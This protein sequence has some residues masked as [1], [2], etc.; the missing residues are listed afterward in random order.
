MM[1]PGICL[2][3]RDGGLILGTW[4]QVVVVDHDNRPRTRRIYVQVVGE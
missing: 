1:G 3:F 4:Q 2:P